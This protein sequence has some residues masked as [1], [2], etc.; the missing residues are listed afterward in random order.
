MVY[1]IS[2]GSLVT[3][4]RDSGVCK[5]GEVGVCYEVYQLGNRPGYSFIFEGGGYDG[6]SPEDVKL[7]LEVSGCVAKD[8]VSYAFRNVGQLDADYRAGRF[9]GAFEDA[10][11]LDAAFRNAPDAR[12]VYKEEWKRAAS[13]PRNEALEKHGP[14]LEV[15]IMNQ[16]R[17]ESAEP[18]RS[19]TRVPRPAI[20][21]SSLDRR[22]HAAYEDHCKLQQTTPTETGRNEWAREWRGLT[23]EQRQDAVDTERNRSPRWPEAE[24][25]EPECDRELDR[26]MDR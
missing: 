22:A 2:I 14:A 19:E 4:N 8:A 21:L 10:R 7:F 26:D 12:D 25:Q 3:A 24:R 1:P 13:R 15:E 5:A 23:E 16:L 6:F 11:E 20:A 17:R 18:L 9:S